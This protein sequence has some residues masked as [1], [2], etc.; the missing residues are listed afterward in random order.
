MSEE[1]SQTVLNLQT[2]NSATFKF[3]TDDSIETVQNRIGTLIGVHPDRLRIYVEG[4]FEGDYYAKDSRKW[5]N[6][7]LR[8]SP[9]GKPVR[10]SL[11]YYNSARDPP[12]VFDQTSYD[13]SAWMAIDSTSD[14]PFRE[15]RLLG[16]TEDRSWIYPQ[17]NTDVPEHLPPSARVTVDVRALFKTLHPNEIVQF[18]VIPQTPLVPQ[19]ELLYYPRLRPISPAKVPADVEKSIARQTEL[20]SA[21]STLR[22]PNPTKVSINQVR[23]KLPLVNTD[24]GHAIRNRFEQIFYGTTVSPEI[25][26]IS[27]FSSRQE[28]SRHKFFTDNDEKKP[29]L[30]VR[31]WSYWWN[32]TKPS[33]NKPALIIYR[34]NA[35]GTYDRITVNSTDI[36]ISCSRGEEGADTHMELQQKAKEFLVSIDGL[37]AFLDPADYEDERW[38]LQDMSGVVHYDTELKEADFRRFD[39]LRSLYDITDKEKLVFKFLRTDDTD[40]GLSNNETRILGM[41]REN[42]ATTPEEVHEQI[43]D[44][45][46]PDSTALLEAV[47]Q[48]LTDNPEIGERHYAAFPTFKLSSTKVAVTHAP[49]MKRVVRYITVLRDILM[50]PDNPELDDVCPKRMEVVESESAAIPEETPAAAAEEDSFLDELLGDIAGIGTAEK[51]EEPKPEKKAAKKVKL[52]GTRTSLADYFLRQLREF[53]PET[54]DPSE[55]DMYNKCDKPRQPIILKES[56]LA[57]FESDEL[58]AYDPRLSGSAAVL[59]VKEP[60]GVVICPEYWC[61]VDRIPLK[62]SQLVDGTKCPICDGKVRSSV[63]AEEKTQDV[64]EYSVIKRDASSVYPGYI[65]YKAKKSGKQIPCCYTTAQTTKISYSQPDAST[66]EPEP[67]YVLGE[68]KTRLEELR[69]AYI[70]KAIGRALGL[71][72]EYK[73]TVEAMNRIQSGQ[74][75]YFRAGVGHA[76]TTLGKI[77]GVTT[78]IPSPLMA[79]EVTKRC[80]F[81]RSWS[82]ADLDSV[83]DK[84]SARVVSISQA[85]DEKALSPLEELEYVALTLNCMVYTLFVKGDDIHSACFMNIGAVRRTNK[86][87]LVLVD[88]SDLSSIDYVAHVSRTSAFPVFN[89]NLYIN[90]FPKELVPKL[91]TLRIQSCVRD[92]PTI[93]KAIAFIG[94]IPSLKDRIP[95]FKVVLDPYS[96]AQAL[97]FPKT[98]LLPFRPTSQIPT[99]LEQRVAGYS[100]IAQSDYP[101]KPEMLA[102]L[103]QAADVHPGYEYAHD[104][105][106]AKHVV[107]ELVT[108]SGLR[109][110]V[111]TDE[112]LDG[113]PTEITETSR[114]L[115]EDVLV[116]GKPDP[117]AVKTSRSVTYE[118]EIF[119][120]LLYQLTHDMQGE[121]YAELRRILSQSSPDIKELRPL[122]KKWFD[123]TLS[124][125]EADTPPTFYSKMRHSCT[126]ADKSD[127]SGLCVWDGASCKVQVKQVRPTLE[128]DALES[129][130]VS[131]LV[132][133]DKIRSVVF[134]NRM[135]PFFSSILYLELP[136][137]TIL[138]DGD[139]AANLKV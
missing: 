6:L 104:A 24:F 2:G 119:E 109:I 46:I 36:T 59:N 73:A 53:D 52:K 120:F 84:L 61:T 92:I 58:S 101:P 17:N 54:Y 41:L 44:L 135:S 131:T 87:V 40:I 132:S 105:G 74:S 100:E 5:E 93:D 107:T 4:Q 72:L 55:S 18:V 116:Y 124:F 83:D 88:S 78:P 95:E 60:D 12:F 28:Q 123:D 30:D 7:F 108:R 99:F 125:S 80:S 115:G 19:L 29:F 62:E 113:D 122:V 70:P 22:V 33:K 11:G 81:F 129:R 79:P 69:I 34:G 47:K 68:T 37:A 64:L 137:E 26:V 127:C 133:N 23:W 56:E 128:R 9:E 85:Y 110:P 32:A 111:L 112:V 21:L 71:P 98:I 42:V 13:K 106:N 121:D 16:V 27:F 15:R 67:Y 63:K 75:G 10:K 89:G 136:T 138:S 14:A 118:A 45:S 3:F 91:E 77:L 31:T 38:E 102:F 94:K 90:L 96:R 117:E 66:K 130:L 1:V 86:A 82:K 49:D 8:M 103:K 65:K 134:E 50:R 48:L 25:P 126:G 57:K 20:V 39:C 76:A 43:P 35:R 114:E 51:K 139:V 97:F